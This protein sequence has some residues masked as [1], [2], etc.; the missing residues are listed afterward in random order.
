M[1]RFLAKLAVLLCFVNPIFSQNTPGNPI[2]ISRLP[3][4]G[5]LLDKGWKFRTG[6]NLEWAKPEYND[7]DWQTINPTLDIH[8]SLPQVPKSGICWFRVRLSI[9]STLNDQLVLL[10]QQSGASEIYLN[11]KLL[12]RFGVLSPNPDK[13]KAF[14][15]LG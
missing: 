10:I 5:I 8:D 15:P 9:D 14:S 3:P 6:D 13:V 11:G 2:L 7:R 4:E 12:Y 1:R